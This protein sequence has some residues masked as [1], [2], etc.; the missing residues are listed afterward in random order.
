LSSFNFP[1][2]LIRSQCNPD[3]GPEQAC[4]AIRFSPAGTVEDVMALNHVNNPKHWRDRAAEM[5]AL[6]DTMKDTE[7]IKIMRRLADDYDKLADRAQQ[8]SGGGGVPPGGV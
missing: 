1:T 7:A 8:R 5:R 3:D 6:A 4:R 2:A